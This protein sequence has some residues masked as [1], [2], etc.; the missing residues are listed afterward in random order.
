MNKLLAVFIAVISISGCTAPTVAMHEQA[1][2]IKLDL[3]GSFDISNCQFLGE[4]TGSEGHWYS[5]LFFPNDVLLQ[6]AINKAKNN[7]LS[8]GANTLVFSRPQDFA[9]SVTLLGTSYQCPDKQI[10]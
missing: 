10:Q 4:V 9:T 8:L 5:Y 3:H 2:D 6:G 7:A 1:R